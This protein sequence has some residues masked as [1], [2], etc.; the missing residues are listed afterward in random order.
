MSKHSI[1]TSDAQAASIVSQELSA[2]GNE[3]FEVDGATFIRNRRFPEW[4]DANHV[5][6]VTASNPQEI[7]R[8]LERV[9]EEFGGF[10]HRRFDIGPDTP[11]VLA[12][13]LL[14]EGYT[15][16]DAIIMLLR[17]EL[18]GEA[19]PADIR[20]VKDDSEWDLLAELV[21]LDRQEYREQ[22]GD[23]SADISAW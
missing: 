21:A 23:H 1:A 8:L 22:R 19:K 11:P 14:L 9:E 18:R 3:R 10:P 12:A 7:D 16:S 4:E 6:Y 5:A 2:L 17:G 20:L 13:R 15:R